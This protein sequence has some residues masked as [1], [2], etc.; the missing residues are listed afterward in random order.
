[1][2]GN[3]YVRIAAAFGG[4]YIIG[5][6]L[7]KNAAA[8]RP[9]LPAAPAPKLVPPGGAPATPEGEKAGA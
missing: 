4:A 9:V 1:M 5:M 7:K 8:M 3:I 2:F 6:L